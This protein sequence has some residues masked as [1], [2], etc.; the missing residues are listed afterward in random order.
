MVEPAWSRRLLYCAAAALASVQIVPR[1]AVDYGADGDARRSAAAALHLAATGSYAP[2]RLPGNPLFEGVLAILVPWGGHVASNTFVASSYVAA[3]FAFF[4][5]ARPLPSRPVLTAL[6]ALTPTVVVNAATTMDYMPGLALLLWTYALVSEGHLRA[7]AVL[8]GLATGFRITN[9][10]FG[11]PLAGFVL[12]RGVAPGRVARLGG[13]ALALAAAIYLPVIHRC[14]EM[15]EMP[16]S[17]APFSAYASATAARFTGIVGLPAI[18]ALVCFVALDRRRITAARSRMPR[19]EL[20]AEGGAIAVFSAM[21][22]LHSDERDYLL[23]VVPFVLLQIGRSLAPRRMPVLLACVLS[24]ALVVLDPRPGAGLERGLI[25]TDYQKRAAMLELRAN[26]A[27]EVT[28]EP[29][30]LLTGLGP[31]LTHEN[32]ALQRVDRAALG[33]LSTR[34]GSRSRRTSTASAAETSF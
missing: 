7:G 16:R 23:P 32:P 14:A 13:A 4:R 2:S 11:L 10:L 22:A 21:F 19:P 18:G 15:L 20:V 29:A 3:I 31:V 6:F 25:A 28:P 8:L 30:V 5:T 33:S 17:S 9:V 1:L 27:R 34:P 26:I 12:M 24:P